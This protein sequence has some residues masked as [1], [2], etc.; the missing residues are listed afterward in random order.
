M[1]RSQKP[2]TR[3]KVEDNSGAKIAEFVGCPGNS[4][5]RRQLRVG[6][7]IKVT[8][9]K[10]LPNGAIKPGQMFYSVIV[11]TKQWTHRKDGSSVQSDQNRIVLLD[12]KR[13]NMVGTRVLS[14][15][16]LEIAT[17]YPQI[18]SLATGSY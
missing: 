4:R 2:S 9:K 1:A 16:A 11:S 6:D 5:V 17:L 7:V 18:S 8:I 10:A 15:V 12:A 13:E 14:L 3:F